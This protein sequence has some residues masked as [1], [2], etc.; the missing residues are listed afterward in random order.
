MAEYAREQKN[1]LSRVIANNDS[2]SRKCNDNNIENILSSQRYCPPVNLI[3][4]KAYI[5]QRPLGQ[6]ETHNGI[7]GNGLISHSHI[8][9][10]NPHAKVVDKVQ[11]PRM[12]GN[13]G[14]NIGYHDAGGG[15]GVLFS[16]KWK[17]KD[18]Q[19]RYIFDDEEKAVS[20]VEET[21]PS[22]SYSIFGYKCHDYVNDVRN[23]YNEIN[24]IELEDF[25]TDDDE[26]LGSPEEDELE[27]LD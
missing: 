18:Y 26:L 15:I 14:R 1:K 13:D 5:C 11:D 7:G 3:Q 9:F 4:A 2:K 12:G 25:D 6:N 19:D 23:K 24:D 22:P 27:D 21:T 8:I 10:D 16:E 20:A 17:E